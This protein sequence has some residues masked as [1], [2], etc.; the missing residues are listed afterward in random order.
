MALFLP[1]TITFTS[2]LTINQLVV[3]RKKFRKNFTEFKNS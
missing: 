2:Q 1:K 3:V